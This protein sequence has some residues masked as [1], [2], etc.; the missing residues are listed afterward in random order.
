MPEPLAYLAGRLLP[1][2]DARLPL[3]DA[4]FILGATVTDLARTFRYR[5]FRWADHLQRFRQSCEGAH[6]P[7]PL[8]D[9][10]L[11]DI[12]ERV[13]EHHKALLHPDADLAVVVFAT[14]G[15]VGYY[16]GEPGGG[17]APAAPPG[18]AKVS[19]PGWR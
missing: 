11:T 5:L 8:S 1:Q 12:A 14:P 17:G 15:V 9:D 4:G 18:V 13:V 2:T 3:N 16:L 19:G 6:I 10:Q 7:Q